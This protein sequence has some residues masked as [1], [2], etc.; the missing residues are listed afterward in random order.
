MADRVVAKIAA[1]AALEALRTG[2]GADVLPR[3]TSAR[4][5][6]SVRV[7]EPSG[8]GENRGEARVSLDIEL[9]YPSDIGGQCGE[10]RRH[11]TNR[12][13]ALADMD[14]PEVAVRVR[15]LHA[16]HLDDASTGGGL[17]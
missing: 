13:S 3:D 16:P 15:R 12:V 8:R 5:R 11:V 17:R 10:V 2:S 4:P 14:V 9:G 1:R 7:R 6:A